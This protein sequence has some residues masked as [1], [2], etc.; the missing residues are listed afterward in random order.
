[1]TQEI[2]EPNLG[3]HAVGVCHFEVMT[4]SQTTICA[5]HH[6]ILLK[7][8]YA[9]TVWWASTSPYQVILDDNGHGRQSIAENP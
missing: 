8:F 5:N 9:T 4:V 3:C 2:M 1:M 7:I 6:Q